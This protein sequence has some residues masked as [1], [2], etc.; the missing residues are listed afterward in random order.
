M[1]GAVFYLFCENGQKTEP[2]NNHVISRITNREA[3]GEAFSAQHMTKGNVD[4]SIKKRRK[5]QGRG[6]A[7]ERGGRLSGVLLH[8]YART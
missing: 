5:H 6:R 3:M 8:H 2:T 7:M 4:N 1:V